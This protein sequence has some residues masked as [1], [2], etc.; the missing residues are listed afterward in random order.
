VIERYSR[1][2][3]AAIWSEERK[4]AVWQEIEAIALEGWAA[5]GV[6]PP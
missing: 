4:L 1:P 3:M 6:V 2:E 5:E